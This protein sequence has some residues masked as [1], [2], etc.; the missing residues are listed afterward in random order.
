MDLERLV[1]DIQ[2]SGLFSEGMSKIVIEL[3]NGS[4]F[5]YI[6]GGREL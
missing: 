4:E 3:E 2:Y 5:A 1:K 6:N